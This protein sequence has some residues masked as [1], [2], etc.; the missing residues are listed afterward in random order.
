MDLWKTLG[1]V[2]GVALAGAAAYAVFKITRA[3]LR[4]KAIEEAQ[5]QNLKATALLIKETLQ[6]G[7]YGKVKVGLLDE[8][9]DEIGE[10]FTISAKGELEEDL[11]EGEVIELAA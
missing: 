8:N 4:K 10:D 5:K 2:A 9:Y 1:I 3:Y 11:E 6:S 7:D